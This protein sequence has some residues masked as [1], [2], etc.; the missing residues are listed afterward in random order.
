MATK[1]SIAKKKNKN[2]QQK[3]VS[4]SVKTQTDHLLSIIR[5]SERNITDKGSDL[6]KFFTEQAKR[7]R[8]ELES[9]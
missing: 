2:T 3:Q 9:L 6:D 5:I 7:L 8:K 1:K 4:V